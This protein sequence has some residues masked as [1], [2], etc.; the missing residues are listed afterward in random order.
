MTKHSQLWC[1]FL[2]ISL[3]FILMCFWSL[4]IFSQEKIRLKWVFRITAYRLFYLKERKKKKKKIPTGSNWKLTRVT[5]V[6]IG[7]MLGKIIWQHFQHLVSPLVR[8]TKIIAIKMSWLLL[9]TDP[10]FVFRK[11][12]H[13]HYFRVLWLT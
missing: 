1:S 3:W 2:Q 6:R 11:I 13:L 10:G 4:V 8:L 9:M 7:H 5:R 12:W